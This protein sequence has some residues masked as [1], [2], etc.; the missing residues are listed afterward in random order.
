MIDYNF[1]NNGIKFTNNG[2]ETV[3]LS[4]CGIFTGTNIRDGNRIVFLLKKGETKKP[5][6]N[7][8]GYS[9]I[10]VYK[11][12]DYLFT[13]SLHEHLTKG[14]IHK[15]NLVCIGLN[16]TGTTSLRDSLTKQGFSLCD[17]NYGH[18]FMIQD[19][20]NGNIY[21]SLS[22]LESPKF[23]L[24]EDLPFSLTKFYQKIY[25]YRPQDYYILTLRDNV[26]QWVDS[27]IR[28]YYK[29]LGFIDNKKDNKL[30]IIQYPSIRRKIITKN[31]LTLQM[32]DWG[33][34][35]TVDLEN[36][37]RDVYN[38]HTNNV[39]NFFDSKINS[40][41]ISIHV[42]KKDELLRLSKYVD[43]NTT[44]N[45][46]LWVNKKTTGGIIKN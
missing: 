19:F 25:D 10:D 27:V 30:Y 2:D 13:L 7:Y 34:T 43:F 39:F 23:N 3:K 29:D 40:K 37:L 22:F 35:S 1:D 32:Y 6:F 11:N 18:Q 38:R 5:E 44:E 16:K 33:I 31:Y 28:Y 45:D 26:D 9:S 12:D 24:Y 46:F 14:D 42:S 4:I 15:P 20:H 21:T 36:K 8:V 41:F 17:E